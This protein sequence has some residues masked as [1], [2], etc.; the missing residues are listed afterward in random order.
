MK[1]KNMENRFK[2]IVN[3]YMGKRATISQLGEF[4]SDFV[5]FDMVFPETEFARFS[6]DIDERGDMK[7]L[8]DYQ[9]HNS[10]MLGE[11]YKYAVKK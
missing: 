8:L 7:N 6:L 4:L 3:D 10:K 1:E 11:L 9:P 5:G 2:A